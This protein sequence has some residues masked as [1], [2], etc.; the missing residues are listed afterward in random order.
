MNMRK[1]QRVEPPRNV[2]IRVFLA[3]KH[4]KK[5]LLIIMAL[6][7]ILY[8]SKKA[9]YLKKLLGKMLSI[10]ETRMKNSLE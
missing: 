1:L 10:V 4:N 3:L 6:T 5:K 8:W 2:I 9:G 7:T